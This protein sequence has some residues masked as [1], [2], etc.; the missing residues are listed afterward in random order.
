M[1]DL[2]DVYRKFGEVAEAAQLLE[3][4]LG[5]LLLDEKFIAAG[6]LTKPN[7]TLATEIYRSVNQQT[8]GQLF[9]KL[10]TCGSSLGNLEN[11]LVEAIKERNRLFHSF[12]RQHNFRRNSSEGCQIMIDDLEKMHDTILDAY[13][14]ILLLSGIDLGSI[15]SFPLPTKHVNI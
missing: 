7:S 15:E 1:P 8:S 2:D 6:L 5:S 4:E 12:Y 14:K 9:K 13:Q 10:R 11:D 3:T